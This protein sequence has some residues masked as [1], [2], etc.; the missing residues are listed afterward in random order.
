MYSYIKG[1]IDEVTSSSV[2]IDNNGIG[3]NVFV[4][5]PYSFNIGE[6]YKIYLYNYIREDEYSLYGFK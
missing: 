2:I 3:Y 1:I 6:E 4:S 5:N